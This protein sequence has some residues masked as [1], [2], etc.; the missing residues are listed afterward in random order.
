MLCS[1]LPCCEF[2]SFSGGKV[3]LTLNKRHVLPS[4]LHFIFDVTNKWYLIPVY[5][6]VR[7]SLM[8]VR[9]IPVSGWV[10]YCFELKFRVGKE[11]KSNAS[12][13]VTEYLNVYFPFF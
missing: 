7:V 12:I 11:W 1:A 4:Q 3:L 9:S 10:E 2:D 8:K 13:M 6:A 5:P